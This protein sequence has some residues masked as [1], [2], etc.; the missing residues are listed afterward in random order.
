M[1]EKLLEIRDLYVQY[2]TDDGVVHAL[3]GFNLELNRGECLGLVGDLKILWK[4]FTF[5][6]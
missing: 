2:N 5:F 6:L 1:E 3:N 4:H